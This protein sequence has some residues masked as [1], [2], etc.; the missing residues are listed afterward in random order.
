MAG[1]RHTLPLFGCIWI[2]KTEAD[3]DNALSFF[4]VWCARVSQDLAQE[5]HSMTLMGDVM[6]D[7][8]PY[9]ALLWT[10]DCP[11][12][13]LVMVK[14]ILVRSFYAEEYANKEMEP[15]LVSGIIEALKQT[16]LAEQQA[17]LN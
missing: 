2:M 1:D 10:R 9:I 4:D 12:S 7:G 11:D 5:G 3:M 16:I 13:A 6:D 15:K 17:K 8:T 14:H